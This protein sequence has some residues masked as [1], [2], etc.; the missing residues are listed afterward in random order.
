MSPAPTDVE[1]TLNSLQHVG[2]MRR[3]RPGEQGSKDSAEH[4]QGK[5]Q[6]SGEDAFAKVEGRG[7]GLH[8]RLQDARQGHL[9]LHAFGMMT[10]VGGSVMKRYE[11]EN[12]KTEHFIDPRYHREMNVVVEEDLWVL[13]EAD[14]EAVQLLT[15]WREEQW[16]ARRAHDVVLGDSCC[17]CSELG[18]S[19]RGSP[20][21]HNEWR[22]AL[23]FGP[24]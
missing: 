7:H 19:R 16:E 20:P 15:E 5:S 10:E 13:K 24:P 2:M 12:V 11:P 8:S 17:L 3:G 22:P 18:T 23:P 9:K 21:F 6:E 1:H 14:A 4:R